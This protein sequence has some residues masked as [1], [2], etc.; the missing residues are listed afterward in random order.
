VHQGNLIKGI[1]IMARTRYIKPDFFRDEDLKNLPFEARLV[2]I[3]LWTEADRE[4]RLEDRP[5]RLK[6]ELMPY[7]KVDV[8]KVLDML[9]THKN[10]IKRPFIIRYSVNDEK[11]IQI[12]KWHAHQKPHHSEKE[13]II[14][15]IPPQYKPNGDGEYSSHELEASN[16][17]I[18]VKQPLDTGEKKKE[19]FQEF[20]LLTT[21]EHT[22]LLEKL[23]ENTLNDYITCLNN[24]IGSKGKKYN[25]HYHTILTWL[26]T[27]ELKM[28]PSKNHARREL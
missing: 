26:R 7:D 10:S 14:P 5:E 27:D 20:V 28:L 12:L 9:A 13:S 16:G 15:P 25:S 18:T 1:L 17:V 4:G 22:K 3:G 23:G 21:E 6:I 2:Y 19:L 11:Y 24:Y 8:N